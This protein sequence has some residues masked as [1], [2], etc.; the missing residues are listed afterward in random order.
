MAQ[1]IFYTLGLRT[2]GFTGPLRGAMNGVAGLKAGMASLAS[3]ALAVAGPLLGVASAVA[4][5]GKSLSA[6]A[7][8]ET[9]TTSLKVMIGSAEEATAVLA[10]LQAFAASTPFELGADV[11]PAARQLLAMGSATETVVAELRALGDVASGTGGDL[12]GLVAIYGKARANGK[13][14]NDDLIQL[15]NRGI[16]IFKE[17]AKVTGRNEEEIRDLA[18]EGRIGFGHLVQVF[19]NLTAE[20]GRYFGMMKEQSQTTAG[21]L[22]TLKDAVHEIFVAFG[23]P[24]NDALKPVL[25]DLATF[26]ASLQPQIEAFGSVV[27]KTVAGIYA[28]IKEGRVGEVLGLAFEAAGGQ[29]LNFLAAG[30]AALA[31]ELARMLGSAMTAEFPRISKLLGEGQGGDGRTFMDR[32]QEARQ[33]PLVDAGGAWD[34]L[35]VV[36]DSLAKS[37]EAAAAE[38]DRAAAET[39]TL[40]EALGVAGT[41]VDPETADDAEPADEK[42]RPMPAV[43]AGVS[44]PEGRR[45]IRVNNAAQSALREFERQK[46]HGEKDLETWLSRSPTRIGALQHL[47]PGRMATTFNSGVQEIAGA[48]TTMPAVERTRRRVSG[49]RPIGRTAEERQAEATAAAFK[50]LP[51]AEK[52]AAYLEKIYQWIEGNLARA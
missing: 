51:G 52:S 25:R 28:A 35:Q 44:M 18:S 17:L 1:G 21:L 29:L 43:E 7:D 40:A 48:L 30:F 26:V 42:A 4:A 49:S 15:A 2:G 5:V 14:F 12:N 23:T 20:G 39:R 46:K 45:R 10:K 13:L 11:A 19:S 38:T 33:N 41:Q 22:S 36:L 47:V 31:P 16:P 9:L 8:R 24:L 32:F 27:G 6:A 50:K 34:R 3:S 37:T